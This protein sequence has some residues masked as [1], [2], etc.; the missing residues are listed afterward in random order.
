MT[1]TQI[2]TTL[3]NPPEDEMVKKLTKYSVRLLVEDVF[4]VPEIAIRKSI[5]SVLNAWNST[6]N[7]QVGANIA[8]TTKF[9]TKIIKE[10]T[11]VEIDLDRLKNNLEHHSPTDPETVKQIIFEFCQYVNLVF[12]KNT[13]QKMT[14]EEVNLSFFSFPPPASELVCPSGTYRRLVDSNREMRIDRSREPILKVHNAVVRQMIE[15][16][17]FSVSPGNQVHV[18]PYI[19]YILGLVESK[20]S[21]AQS[22]ISAKNHFHFLNKYHKDFKK[23]LTSEINSSSDNARDIHAYLENFYTKSETFKKLRSSSYLEESE[24]QYSFDKLSQ[25]DDILSKKSHN[26]LYDLLN[27]INDYSGGSSLEAEIEFIETMYVIAMDGNKFYGGSKSFL[28]DLIGK[29]SRTGFMAR[30]Q[31]HFDQN[32]S[33]TLNLK[34]KWNAIKAY[35][36][37]SL[38]ERKYIIPFLEQD[39]LKDYNIISLINDGLPTASILHKL[40]LK[41][42]P[43]KALDSFK[44]CDANGMGVECLKISSRPDGSIIARQLIDEYLNSLT[45]HTK[46]AD[47][48]FGILLLSE[49]LISELKV[50]GFDSEVVQWILDHNEIVDGFK[51]LTNPKIFTF[52][53]NI[54]S[55]ELTDAIIDK[56]NADGD[57]DR[58]LLPRMTC[59]HDIT[60]SKT[61][62]CLMDVAARSGNIY[63]IKKLL[64]IRPEMASTIFADKSLSRALYFAIISDN[65]EL[66]RLIADQGLDLNFKY[67]DGT[68]PA[69]WAVKKNNPEA[70]K[71]LGAAGVREEF[72][73]SSSDHL[74][75]EGKPFV[76]NSLLQA[77]EMKQPEVVEAL[78]KA[79]VTVDSLNASAMDSDGDNKTI[80]IYALSYSSPEVVTMLATLGADINKV[81][82]VRST[83][84]MMSEIRP[85]EFVMLTERHELIR[86]LIEAGADL[87]SANTLNNSL[88]VFLSRNFGKDLLE[89]FLMSKNKENGNCFLHQIAAMNQEYFTTDLLGLNLARFINIKNK[90]GESP[91]VIAAKAGNIDLIKYLGNTNFN[92]D[93]NIFF[94]LANSADITDEN[95]KSFSDAL[96]EKKADINYQN[97]NSGNTALHMASRLGK[98]DAVRKLLAL[99][100]SPDI[101]NVEGKTADQ[102]A[103]GS[104]KDEIVKMLADVVSQGMVSSVES[105]IP[106]MLNQVDFDL[107]TPLEQQPETVSRKRPLEEESEKSAEPVLKKGTSEKSSVDR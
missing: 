24:L 7:D 46:E 63:F 26:I 3:E 20:D 74:N 51:I 6:P 47:K 60:V 81:C 105:S 11:G 37:K 41:Y 21:Y 66:I 87:T 107:D 22:Q 2:T 45:P 88:E 92:I 99:G 33:M 86:P 62:D 49:L 65:T 17:K 77:I 39:G 53:A 44:N 106:V 31:E 78:V 23:L 27:A 1:R 103:N 16:L 85:I 64:A 91:L 71:I 50:N 67:D 93:D 83:D 96:I 57:L 68:T 94:A 43:V 73:L 36:Q 79:G 80:I 13:Q 54:R 30:A 52:I 97:S 101:Q 8:R 48:V 76:Y 4:K 100:L 32:D 58:L 89:S 59:N 34:N 84:E 10:Q 14:E 9:F 75:D 61:D 28:R 102:V 104:H 40:S 70:I 29:A 95:L 82:V 69:F 18:K 12:Y 35:Y 42:T 90:A 19:E 72:L 15:E 56:L 38:E 55:K 25:V 98:V 5:Q